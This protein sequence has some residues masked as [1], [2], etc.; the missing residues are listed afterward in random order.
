MCV[1]G[2]ARSREIGFSAI[3][4]GAAGPHGLLRGPESLRGAADRRISGRRR[5]LRAEKRQREQLNKHASTGD[6]MP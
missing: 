3:E 4:A 5:F 1:S 2:A 6:R